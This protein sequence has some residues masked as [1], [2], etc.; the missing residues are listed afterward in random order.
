M[1]RRRRRRAS[2]SAEARRRVNGGDRRQ[3]AVALVEGDELVERDAAETVAVGAHERPRRDAPCSAS[4]R[5][6][7]IASRPVSTACTR[8]SGGSPPTIS[9]FP[10]LQGDDEVLRMEAIIGEILLDDL[11]AVAAGDGEIVEAEGGIVAHHVP[12]DRPL[13]DLDH[14]LGLVRSFFR[15]AG[16]VPAGQNYD[17]HQAPARPS[18]FARLHT[19]CQI[20]VKRS[21]KTHT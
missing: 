6:P 11:A 13:A 5:P 20:S 1:R 17:L 8:Q 7:V 14:R 3:L 10:G 9:T 15:Y 19:L 2:S 4:R 18:H 12:Q 21:G 16:A